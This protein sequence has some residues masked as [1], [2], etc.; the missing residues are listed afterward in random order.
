MF[1]TNIYFASLQL[2]AALVASSMGV[3]QED[4]LF[5]WLADEDEVDKH[6]EQKV[7]KGIYLTE[8]NISIYCLFI[9]RSTAQSS[10]FWWTT[11]PRQ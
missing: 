7:D 4:V 3:D 10:W 9:F 8:T 2:T 1:A 6:Y 5:S 11:R